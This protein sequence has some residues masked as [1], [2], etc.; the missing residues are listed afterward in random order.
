MGLKEKILE[1]SFELFVSK[2]YDETTVSDIIKRAGSSRGGFYHHFDS[3]E[4]ILEVITEKYLDQFSELFNTTIEQHKGSYTQLF[5]KIFLIFHEYKMGQIKDWPKFQK[6]FSFKGNHIIILKMARDTEELLT[7]IYTRVIRE[8]V[9]QGEFTVKYPEALAG[10]W[11]REIMQINRLARKEFYER[12]DGQDKAFVNQLEFAQNMINRELG[13]D[14][15]AVRVTSVVVD[16]IEQTREQ[17][18]QKEEGS[19]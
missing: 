6:L 11:T 15:K 9:E 1:A 13:L 2:G 14:G 18:T 4:D 10:L 7:K 5:N 19:Q 8:G 16:Y 17:I 3:K 12:D